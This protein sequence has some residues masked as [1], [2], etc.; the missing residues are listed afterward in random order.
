MNHPEHNEQAALFR[1][2]DMQSVAYP[3]LRWMFAV[4]NSARRSPRQ[5][6]WMKAEGLRSGVWDIFLPAPRPPWSGLFIEMKHG[7]NKLSE[8][9]KQF[10][11]ALDNQYRFAVCYNW[12]DAKIVILDYLEDNKF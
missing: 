3:E 12:I 2:A 9:Q 8:P 4:P 5:G 1:W 11:A 7:T 6:A 10:R